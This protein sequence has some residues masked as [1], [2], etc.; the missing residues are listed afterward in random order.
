MLSS[1]FSK[2]KDVIGL[3]PIKG[4]KAEHLKE[5]VLNVIE[6]LT[7]SGYVILSIISDNNRVNRK[8][9]DL[10]CDGEMSSTF[11]NPFRK[12]DKIFLFFDTV[13]IFKSFRNNWLNQDDTCQSFVIPPFPDYKSATELNA[14]KMWAKVSDLR[15]LY[16]SEEGN[17]IKLAPAL[18]K[19]VLNPVGIERQNVNL[20]IKL[21]DDKNIAALKTTS[22]NS[23]DGTIQLMTIISR[24]FKIVN[25]KSKFKGCALRDPYQNPVFT[26]SDQNI[27]FLRSFIQWLDDWN[28]LELQGCENEKK[29]KNKR[30]GKLT[31]DT[32]FSITHTTKTLIL[33]TKYMLEDLHFEYVL[34]GK[35]QTDDLEARFGQYRQMSGATY[36]VTLTQILES[37]K[38]LKL[39]SLIKLNSSISGSFSLIDFL[40]TAETQSNQ[41]SANSSDVDKFDNNFFFNNPE[42]SE[43]DLMILIYITGYITYKV[44]QNCRNCF[45]IMSTERQFQL[46]CSPT[47]NSYIKLLDRGGLC[48]AKEYFNQIVISTYCLFL[49]IISDKYEKIFLNCSSHKQLLRLLALKKLDCTEFEL[50][51]ESD[52]EGKCVTCGNSMLSLTK[53]TI[54]IFSNILLNNY[55]KVKS[56][57]TGRGT[58]SERKIK[59]FSNSAQKKK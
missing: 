36:H 1:I 34:L 22:S 51:T 7:A 33:L 6:T 41:T 38:K 40:N 57:T 15:K 29:S 13:H 31:K 11:V 59:K 55:S 9:F 24:W 44:K 47:V 14:V 58:T 5:L 16:A 48:Y 4:L 49:T 18:S 53:K 35:F 54:D 10:L 39:L 3:Y 17:V 32:Q 52:E 2:N 43:N 12:T 27:V 23:A 42:V 20:C 30:N 21:F 46:E 50:A 28:N 25:V 45:R 26:L 37:E 56:D 19:K 8:M